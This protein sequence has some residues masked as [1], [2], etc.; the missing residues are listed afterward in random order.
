MSDRRLR[1]HTIPQLLAAAPPANAGPPTW[2]DFAPLA[3]KCAALV[4]IHDGD[5]ASD[6]AFAEKFSV[7]RAED[8]VLAMFCD[9]SA[10]HLI[11]AGVA[12]ARSGGKP[13]TIKFRNRRWASSGVAFKKESGDKRW[14]LRGYPGEDLWSNVN[15]E[16]DGF[17]RA[18]ALAEK[19]LLEDLTIEKVYVFSDSM[20]V[21]RGIL[22]LPST[23]RLPNWDLQLL[24]EVV[25]ALVR[26]AERVEV[27]LFWVPSHCGVEGNVQADKAAACARPDKL[28]PEAYPVQTDNKNKSRKVGYVPATTTTT[29]TAAAAGP[30]K[31]SRPAEKYLRQRREKKKVAEY[32][33]RRA[34]DLA[35]SNAVFEGY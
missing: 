1:P 28:W 35:V 4:K 10:S 22:E 6:K 15:A 16:L 25:K 9:G 34:A 14:E 29:S 7:P 24:L 5:Y 13:C 18:V 26:L 19:R 2:D 11:P 23:R 30:S 32:E 21:L 27:R 12:Q 20:S 33:G 31:H 8:S 3:D 17:G